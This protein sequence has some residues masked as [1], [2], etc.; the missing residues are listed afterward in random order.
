LER[1]WWPWRAKCLMIH[2]HIGTCCMRGWD[3]QLK[4]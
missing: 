1:W 4:V 3:N 2:R